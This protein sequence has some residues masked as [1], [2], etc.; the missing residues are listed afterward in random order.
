MRGRGNR[1]AERSLY[2]YM[3][4]QRSLRSTRM[5]Q[6]SRKLNM[7]ITFRNFAKLIFDI[8]I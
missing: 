8:Q 2:V 4:A 5:L 7:Y 1:E 3:L 6:E